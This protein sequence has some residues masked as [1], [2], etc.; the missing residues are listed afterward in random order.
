[1]I[2]KKTVIYGVAFLA[3]IS[4]G[5]AVGGA[6]RPSKIFA[7]KL[8][9]DCV[10]LHPEM[11][12]CTIH[13]RA[14]ASDPMTIIASYNT[15]MLGKKSGADDFKVLNSGK[16][17]TDLE[18]ETNAYEVLIPLK[19][20]KGKSIGLL[21]TV[22]KYN[23]KYSDSDYVKMSTTSRDKMDEDLP[24]IKAIQT[25]IVARLTLVQIRF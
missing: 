13:A 17:G 9:N 23:P 16:P 19:D 5:G 20:K 6:Q 3:T 8:V 1:M 18:K 24:S 10:T 15:T 7:Q 25:K 4:V 2:H 11:V 21:A 14:S 12:N 22:Y